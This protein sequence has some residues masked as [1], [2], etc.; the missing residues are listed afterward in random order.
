VIR[1]GQREIRNVFKPKI[2]SRVGGF[3][4]LDGFIGNI[5]SHNI[6]L[7][8]SGGVVGAVACSAA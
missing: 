2:V 1:E 5:V 8:V 7:K 3:A 6:R 4:V